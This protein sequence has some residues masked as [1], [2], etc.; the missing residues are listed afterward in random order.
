MLFTK[1]VIVYCILYI[2]LYVRVADISEDVSIEA[3]LTL[4]WK[5]WGKPWNV[6]VV[7][8]GVSAKIQTKHAMNII[9]KALLLQQPNQ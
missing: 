9:T 8:V 2:V 7:I 1:A 4:C 3:G 5:D 6:L